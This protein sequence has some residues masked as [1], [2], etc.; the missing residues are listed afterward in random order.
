MPHD[1]DYIGWIPCLSG[2][3]FFSKTIPSLGSF[4]FFHAN[5]CCRDDN[6]KFLSRHLLATSV[7]DW[8]D[9]KY[10]SDNIRGM[11]R[12]VL[13]G[14]ADS[15]KQL[16]GSIYLIEKNRFDLPGRV[17]KHFPRPN[18]DQEKDVVSQIASISRKL[19]VE[20]GL[21]DLR[22]KDREGCRRLVTDIDSKLT[23]LNAGDPFV[24]KC[25]FEVHRTGVVFFSPQNEYNS[26]SGKLS[27]QLSFYYLKFLLHKHSHHEDDN[28]SLTTLHDIRETCLENAEI[29]IRDIKR[30][31]VDAKRSRRFSQNIVSGIATYGDSLVKSC[32]SLG[33]FEP[34]YEFKSTEMVNTTRGVTQSGYF[35]NVKSSLE[36]L[37]RQSKQE[38]KK[39]IWSKFKKSLIPSATL[40]GPVVLYMNFRGINDPNFKNK[41]VTVTEQYNGVPVIGRFMELINAAVQEGNL[42][43]FISIYIPIVL[44]IP[45]FI[46]IFISSPG[47]F[48]KVIRYV[49]GKITKNAGWLGKA[50][51]SRFTGCI[52]FP[53]AIGVIN[54]KRFSNVIRRHSDVFS[55]AGIL[56]RVAFIL[57][58]FLAV[59][60]V[61]MSIAEWF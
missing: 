23:S 35:R 39:S 2:E 49:E 44:V 51:F 10:F 38:K 52:C 11:F 15:Y 22:E 57:L 37:Q 25:S 8:Q 28:E 33:W 59:Q 27:S 48:S 9:T 17:A 36:I 4:D 41:L 24:H 40:I 5:V 32:D 1:Y 55:L 7:V 46:A 18:C 13:V 50:G 34:G 42:L 12:V 26:P 53:L 3:L 30:G 29:L 19:D 20:A 47:A 16:S 45:F 6:G 21:L 58:V 54:L 43:S 56:R 31:L 60:L 61:F 14:S